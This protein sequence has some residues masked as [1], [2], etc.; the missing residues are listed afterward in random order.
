MLNRLALLTLLICS[1]AIPKQT[2]PNYQTRTI[3]SIG[4]ECN[5]SRAGIVLD[6]IINKNP[7]EARLKAPCNN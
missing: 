1:S 7:E 2:Q 3:Q 4:K 6:D 5:P